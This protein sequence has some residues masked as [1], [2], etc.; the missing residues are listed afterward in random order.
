M[1][2]A[3]YPGSFD[4]ITNAHVE[5]VRRALLVFDKVVVLVGFNLRKKT[6]FTSGERVDLVRAVFATEPR[7]E[8]AA[9]EGLIADYMRQHGY[10][11]LLRGLRAVSDFDYEFQMDLTN[12]HLNSDMQTVFLM[13]SESNLYVA[14]SMVREVA[15]LDGDASG[16]VPP[17]VWRALKFKV[18]QQHA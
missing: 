4:P 15:M 18:E 16:W 10:H 7:V 5:M 14:S 17:V 1:R 2:V 6:M 9:F 12:R 3:V 8:V 11:F 13:A